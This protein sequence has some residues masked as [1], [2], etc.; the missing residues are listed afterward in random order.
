MEEGSGAFT[1]LVPGTPSEPAKVI[2]T[3]SATTDIPIVTYTT[4]TVPDIVASTISTSKPTTG[5]SVTTEDGFIDEATTETVKST[6][7]AEEG[8][9]EF[10]TVSPVDIVKT[11]QSST[12]TP[13]KPVEVITEE[14]FMDVSTT[15]SAS[16]VTMPSTSEATT[17]SEGSGDF[18]TI[19]PVDLVSGT[20]SA[21]VTK[22]PATES[23]ATDGPMSTTLGSITTDDRVV[24]E[25]TTMPTDASATSSVPQTTLAEGSGD[26]TTM[27]PAEIVKTTTV[28]ES[29]MTSTDSTAS[30]TTM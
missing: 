4:Q 11:T 8:S 20:S 19:A 23:V 15:T 2:R 5:Q 13:S 27:A 1:T 17:E 28:T 12:L 16:G 9:G 21:D 22:L 30:V 24:D 25:A 7:P 18:T 6:S 14:E 3:D 29:F 26:V 10:T